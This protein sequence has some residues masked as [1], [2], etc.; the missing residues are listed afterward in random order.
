[1]KLEYSA[2]SAHRPMAILC[3]A[4]ASRSLLIVGNP[5]DATKKIAYRCK[6]VAS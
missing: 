3:K 2:I 4:P 5:T 6:V 1:M